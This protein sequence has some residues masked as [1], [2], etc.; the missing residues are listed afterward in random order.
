MK[1]NLSILHLEDDPNDSELVESL[2][3]EEGIHCHVVRVEARA[4][5]VAALE[6]A[7]FDII[8]ADYALPSFDG[9]S[10][11]EIVLKKCPQ[12]PFILLSGTGGEEVATESLKSGA[13]DYVLKE[14]PS[15]LVPSVCRALREADERTDRQRAEQKLRESE[16]QLRTVIQNMPVLMVAFDGQGTI[17]AWNLEC[18]RVTGYTSQEM[19][20]NLAAAQLLFPDPVQRERLMTEWRC[21]EQDYRDREWTWVAKNGSRREV[22]WCNISRIFPV[23]GWKSWAIGIDVTESRQAQFEREQIQSKLL[24]I[25]KLESLG[26]LAGGIAHDFN[27]LLTGI[28]G[29]AGLALTR[30]EPDSP[31]REPIQK[32]VRASERAAD[33]T[34]Q[35]LAYAGRAN[36]EIHPIDISGHIR[37][38]IS[39]LTSAISK[40]VSLR[41]ELAE[42]LPTVEVDAAQIQQ[43]VMNLVI[44][45]AEA[46]GDKPGTVF[47]RTGMM[48]VDETHTKQLLLG[49]TLFPAA[50]VYL[51]VQDTGCGMSAETKARIFDP[52]FTTKFT[53]R[54][55]GLSA[56]LGIVRAHRGSLKVQS[57]PGSGSSFMVLLPAS[58]K[59][60]EARSEEIAGDLSGEG[61]I[62][63]VDDEPAV[64]EVACQILREYGFDVVKAENGRRAVEVFWERSREIDLVLL[65]MTMPEMGGEEALR[66]MRTIRPDMVAILSSGYNEDETTHRFLD[67][68]PSAFIQKP[69]SPQEL[70]AKIKEVQRRVSRDLQ[71]DARAAGPW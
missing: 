59:S 61:L 3:G 20:G 49:E 30:L 58:A 63:V 1:S 7:Q 41:L 44:N 32:A 64:L 6:Q 66:F 22:S 48:R 33:L 25:Q 62:L 4:D 37:E 38:T 14:R 46:C 53:G 56:V 13:T 2:L 16:E 15:R 45:G 35:M 9:I 23:P 71:G 52:F 17:I 29:N 54:G 34:S 19:V 42:R 50:Y 60:V 28:M 27:N 40:K 70:A 68:G 36:F 39:L 69:Y 24:Q 12:V 43:L 57:T 21:P 47:I 11:L 31:A 5:F 18:E 65:D 55:L 26:V 67:A 51:E 10:A 8:L